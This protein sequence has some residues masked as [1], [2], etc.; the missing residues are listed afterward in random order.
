MKVIF[1]LFIPLI[2]L[3]C[4]GDDLTK[5]KLQVET[6]NNK[7]QWGD[8]LQLKIKNKD[9]IPLTNVAY[10]LDNN[11]VGALIVLQDE[12]L[13]NHTVSAL[14]TY[15][16]KEIT[17]K[18]NITIVADTPPK[19]YGYTILNEYSHDQNAYTQ[20]LE[21]DGETLFESTGLNGKSSLRKVNYTS[22]EVI[23]NKPLDN[24]YFGEGLTLLN[25]QVY[26][27]TWQSKMGFIYD[28]KS[29]ELIRSFP[30]EESEE[31][32]GLCND[33]KVL[34]K[35]DGSNQLWILDAT[36]LK[37]IGKI[38]VMTN[39]RALN[40]LNELE[41][42]N[43]KIYANTYQFEKDVA[44]IIDP[45]SGKVDG[46]IDFSGLKE[47][48]EQHDELNVLN[49]IAYHQKRGTFFVTGKNWSKLF[50]VKIIEK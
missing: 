7:L 48:V 11:P 30:F 24:T 20:G 18:K 3:K 45:R 40:K 10:F 22:G 19:L 25:E 43:G 5:F 14:L 31:G 29:L 17:L 6:T 44:V 4:G 38:Q 35:S 26:Q 42:V 33:G 36:T 27:L 21:F 9:N 32:W 23:E 37:E 47:K 28:K 46:V 34:Y 15:G 1:L 12:P 50:E 41:W 8:S 16:E 49:G 39:K 13:G 2:F